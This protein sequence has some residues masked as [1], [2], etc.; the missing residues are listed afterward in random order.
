MV[1]LQDQLVNLRT[2]CA[3]CFLESINVLDVKDECN[4]QNQT[5]VEFVGVNC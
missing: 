2:Y 3:Y 1:Y 4:R 5:R